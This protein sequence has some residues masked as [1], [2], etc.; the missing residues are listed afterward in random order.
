MLKGIQKN[1]IMV[2]LPSSPCFE[3]A[4]FV[5]KNGKREPKHGEMIKEANRIV[6]ESDPRAMSKGTRLTTKGQRFLLVLYGI[7]GGA[8]SVACLWL[9]FLIFL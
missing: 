7:L 9:G 3:A 4:Y 6:T 5:I 2:K 1:V 8:F